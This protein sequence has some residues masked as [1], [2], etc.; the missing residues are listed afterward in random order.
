MIYIIYNFKF[1][2]PQPNKLL[3]QAV[4]T[5]GGNTRN[6]NVI[7]STGIGQAV[8]DIRINISNISNLQGNTAYYISL[9][10]IVV[11]KFYVVQSSTKTT[12]TNDNNKFIKQSD[13]IDLIHPVGSI[14]TSLMYVEPSKIFKGT[15]WTQ[16]TDRFLYCASV[17]SKTGGSKKINVNQLPSHNHNFNGNNMSGTVHALLRYSGNDDASWGASGVFSTTTKAGS[18]SWD[19]VNYNGDQVSLKFSATPSGTITNTGQGEDYMP[20]YITV[21]AWYRIA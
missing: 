2:T 14:Y 7:D 3:N 8:R 16:I 6:I 17:G 21:Y 4:L 18:R 11:I 15:T 10:N 20:P 19:A 5:Y 12:Q 13:L 9:E 1:I